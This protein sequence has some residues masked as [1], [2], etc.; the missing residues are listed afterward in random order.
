MAAGYPEP[1]LWHY[2]PPKL[3]L[4]YEAAMEME[5]RRDA[6]LMVKL[7]PAILHAVAA[8]NHGDNAPNYRKMI[9]A[10]VADLK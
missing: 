6:R 7:M 4:L 3:E 9:E 10:H 2:S 8:A 5:K 1:S